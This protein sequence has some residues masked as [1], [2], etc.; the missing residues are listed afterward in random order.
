MIR[1]HLYKTMQDEDLMFAASALYFVC[2]APIVY[3]DWKNKNAN[4]YNLPERLISL[5]ATT[6][7]FV[8]SL[9]IQNISLLTNYGPHLVMETLTLLFK[10]YYVSKNR[11]SIYSGGEYTGEYREKKDAFTHM[12]LHSVDLPEPRD[13]EEGRGRIYPAYAVNPDLAASESWMNR[14]DPVI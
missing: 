3:A 4:A 2:Y 9:R 12:T 13:V 7:A 1:L 5:A 14:F 6:L 10:V 8:Y 11:F